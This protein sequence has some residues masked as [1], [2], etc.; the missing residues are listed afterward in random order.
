MAKFVAK[1]QGGS[2]II[3]LMAADQEEITTEQ[4][5]AFAAIQIARELEFI[6]IKLGELNQVLECK[7]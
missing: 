7:D 1:H 2:T 3:G 5:Q 6:S 4:A